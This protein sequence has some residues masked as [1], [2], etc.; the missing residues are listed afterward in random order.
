LGQI[1]IVEK[2]REGGD[3]GR[4][5]SMDEDNPVSKAFAELVTKIESRIAAL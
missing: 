4:P 2:I 5:I 3:S 1:P